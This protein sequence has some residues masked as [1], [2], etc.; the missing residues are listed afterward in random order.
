MLLCR[1]ARDGQ[2]D[3]SISKMAAKLG[4]TEP[5]V[6]K[7]IAVLEQAHLIKVTRGRLDQH[8]DP[9]THL[10]EIIAVK[11]GGGKSDLPPPVK[12][13]Y[14]PGQ[15]ALPG[16]VNDVDPLK[17]KKE[18]IQDKKEDSPKPPLGVESRALEIE[19]ENPGV[20]IDISNVDLEVALQPSP[21]VPSPPSP[22]DLETELML[23]A[24]RRVTG[25]DYRLIPEVLEDVTKYRKCGYTAEDVAD[26]QQVCMKSDWRWTDPKQGNSSRMM[27]LKDIKKYIGAQ[28][29]RTNVFKYDPEMQLDA[30]ISRVREAGDIRAIDAEWQSALESGGD[31]YLDSG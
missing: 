31:N 4:V 22:F 15:P 3:P 20:E 8:G 30:L 2:A 26:A 13:V 18:N 16:V 19:F 29:A 12:D 25:L 1:Y 5:T 6:R 21:P 17:N 9:T 24:I 10:Y 14:H 7:G 27:D 23:V 11:R 28:R